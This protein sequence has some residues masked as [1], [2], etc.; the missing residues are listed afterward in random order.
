MR[1][2]N[3]VPLP[4]RNIEFIALAGVALVAPFVFPEYKTQLAFLWVFILFAL[5][6]DLQGGQ[7]GYNSFGNIV[8][9]GLGMYVATAVQIGI[10]FDLGEWTKAGGEN[11]F[12]HSTAQYFSGF[13]V[14]L[15]AAGSAP[16]ILAL[17]LGRFLLAMRGQYFAICT[18]GLGIAAGE[19]ASSIDVIGAGS[20][21][22]VPIWPDEIGGLLVRDYALYF[23]CAALALTCFIVMRHIHRSRFGMALNAIRDDED[24]AEAMGLPVTVCKTASWTVSAFFLGIAGAL[25]AHIVG[26]IDPTEVAF[27]GATYGVWMVLMAVLGGKGTLWGPVIGALLFQFFKEFSG[28]IS[29]VGNMSC[30]VF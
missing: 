21:M 3:S 20:G 26:F 8:F 17:L 10:A 7:M 6:W 14:G 12:T 9:F 5:T 1:H 11:T 16:M 15:I 18:L 28:L 25:T 19:I 13:V 29:S 24:K 4:R 23:M 27:A 2:H 22:S 30:S